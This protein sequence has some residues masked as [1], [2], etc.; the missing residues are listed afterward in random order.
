MCLKIHFFSEFYPLQNVH[1]GKAAG[2]STPLG[3]SNSRHPL[4]E[5]CHDDDD[6]YDDYDEDKLFNDGEDSNG[7]NCDQNCSSQY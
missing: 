1:T 3:I 6:D 5:F 4:T 7:N 2:R